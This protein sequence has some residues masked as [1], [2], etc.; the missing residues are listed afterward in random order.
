MFFYDEYCSDKSCTH[1][2]PIKNVTR[3]DT[4]SNIWHEEDNI[5]SHRFRFNAVSYNSSTFSAIF[6]FGGQT[7][8][9]VSS[10]SYVILNTTTL[11]VPVSYYYSHHHQVF[12]HITIFLILHFNWLF[13]F[14]ILITLTIII[15]LQHNFY[16]RKNSVVVR[17]LVSL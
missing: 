16:N 3:Y 5:D 6:L 8:Y 12:S 14:S 2:I 15:V 7:T 4:T 9:D 13:I 1:A 10:D 17:L 11:Y